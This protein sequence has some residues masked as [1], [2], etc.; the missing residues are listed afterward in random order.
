[1]PVA[2]TLRV[3]GG[4]WKPL[5]LW[6]LREHILRFGEVK[7]LI[8]GITQKMLTQQLRELEADGIISRQIF[9]EVPPR[10]EYRITVYG[11]TLEPV[12]K[13]MCRWGERHT[14][15]KK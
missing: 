8:P 14:S 11:K 3:I 10:V 4:K 5:I 6:V 7:K 12:L 15:R 13:S 9:P 1:M 2:I